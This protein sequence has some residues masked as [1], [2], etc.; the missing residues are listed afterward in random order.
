MKV[1]TIVRHIDKEG[2]Q[3]L[4]EITQSDQWSVKVH[5][6]DSG[7]RA[8][9]H[10]RILKEV[11]NPHPICNFPA[12]AGGEGKDAEGIKNKNIQESQ[13]HSKSIV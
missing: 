11:T 12:G 3:G 1:G 13:Q 2:P 9:F 6:F 8:V 7:Q 4:G 10:P 5:W